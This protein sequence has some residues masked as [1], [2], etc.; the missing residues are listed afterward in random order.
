MLA[1]VPSITLWSVWKSAVKKTLEHPKADQSQ[2]SEF[3]ARL[4]KHQEA[5]T[6]IIYIDESGFALDGPRTHGYAR[7]GERSYGMRDWNARGRVN[8][9]GAI[10]N[11]EFL[12]VELWNCNINSDVFHA[13]IT[14][15]LLAKCPPAAVIVMDNASFH[16]REDIRQAIKEAGHSLEYLPAYSP[17]LNP[18]E[19]KWA[20]AK[21]I[22]RKLR[23]KPSQL[24]K[25][26]GWIY[27]F[28]RLFSSITDIG[29]SI[30]IW[31]SRV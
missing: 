3:Q 18:I 10:L 2:R 11:F 9:I 8:A 5:D 29:R 12:S 27:D 21:A 25:N 23:C 30:I 31:K 13:W 7:T 24:F 15:A 6:P 1:R 19:R 17:D 26:M 28:L 16:K 22:R 20:Q 4:Q 14:Q